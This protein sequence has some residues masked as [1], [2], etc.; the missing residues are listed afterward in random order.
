MLAGRC[1]Q[2]AQMCQ[3]AHITRSRG[4]CRRRNCRRR[5]AQVEVACVER[6]RALAY[7]WNCSVGAAEAVVGEL[8]CQN[9]QLLAVNGEMAAQQAELARELKGVE[10][11]RCARARAHVRVHEWCSWHA[12]VAA[13]ADADASILTLHDC[14]HLVDRLLRAAACARACAR[15]EAMRF[16]K[17]MEEAQAEASAATADNAQLRGR[18]AAAEGAV[19]AV[20][21][22]ARRRCVVLL[23]T[24]GAEP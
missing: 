14:A 24:V 17:A 19:G 15:R 7:A 13:R 23:A 6:G 9:R 2:L 20:E 5:R 16:R 21:A 18:V 12:A 4:P 22:Y 8:R 11:L 10:F 1:G 3:Q